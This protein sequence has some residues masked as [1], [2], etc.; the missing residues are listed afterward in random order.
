MYLV[1]AQY[2]FCFVEAS[3]GSRAELTAAVARVVLQGV[4]FLHAH[5]VIHSDLKTSNI[6]LDRSQTTA[7]ISDVGYLLGLATDVSCTS[8]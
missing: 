2:Q 4:H 1:R 8:A 7:K 6:L 5:N 3:S